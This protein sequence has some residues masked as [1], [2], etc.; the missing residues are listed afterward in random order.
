M[1]AQGG[2]GGA[3]GLGPERST[4]PAETSPAPERHLQQLTA[5]SEETEVREAGGPFS[6]DPSGGSW[7]R[8][9]SKY[10][11]LGIHFVCVFLFLSQKGENSRVFMELLREQGCVAFNGAV[12]AARGEKRVSSR[13]QSEKI[14]Q[15]SRKVVAIRDDC[16]CTLKF[17]IY[18]SLSLICANNCVIWSS[19]EYII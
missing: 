8:F 7:T 1:T 10:R 2:G 18:T 5:T 4:R 12:P 19:T 11:E 3:P 16:N 13:S 9:T 14:S 6:P 15:I 17:P